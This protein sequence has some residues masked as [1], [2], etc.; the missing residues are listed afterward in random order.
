M[1]ACT[2][3]GNA[4]LTSRRSVKD[5]HPCQTLDRRQSNWLRRPKSG[6]GVALLGGVPLSK[7]LRGHHT[8]ALTFPKLPYTKP[9]PPIYPLRLWILS[10]TSLLCSLL[11]CQF[12]PFRP[13]FAFFC[14]CFGITLASPRHARTNLY[15]P[16]DCPQ[17]PSSII[18]YYHT[19][20]STSLAWGATTTTYPL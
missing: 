19:K 10:S 7:L 9:S 3:H 14:P 12:L 17:I 11:V 5:A 13:R 4:S 2:S 20:P 6:F 15:N 16:G 1:L 18:N 8:S